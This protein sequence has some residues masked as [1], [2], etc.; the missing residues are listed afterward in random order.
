MS[1]G[2]CSAAEP[3]TGEGGRRKGDFASS[4]MTGLWTG[5]IP[6]LRFAPR[7]MTAKGRRKGDFASSG[8]T[9][10]W[11]G[12]I[13]RL[14]FAPRGMTAKGRRKADALQPTALRR[15]DPPHRWSQAL[16]RSVAGWRSDSEPCLKPDFP[17]R[18]ACR[19]LA[20]VRPA[21][22]RGEGTTCFQ[23]A[24][25]RRALH[26]RCVVGQFC[27][28]GKLR[29]NSLPF[30]TYRCI[31]ISTHR[32]RCVWFSFLSRNAFACER[33]VGGECRER[34]TS[35]SNGWDFPS[36]RRSHTEDPAAV[37][38]ITIRTSKRQFSGDTS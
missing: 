14:R 37:T 10:L 5:W 7:G 9:G 1:C 30:V 32:P 22:Q 23:N 8:M 33:N 2:T 26:K 20:T 34:S 25:S 28:A 38:S 3:V 24:S 18:F 19:F 31:K 16:G 17:Q 36:R 29:L 35:R 11:T 15:C 6:R 13:P 21:T 27:L 12:W 4:G